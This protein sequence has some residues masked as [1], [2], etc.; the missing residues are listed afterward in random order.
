MIWRKLEIV[1]AFIALAFL[2][3][4][5]AKEPIFSCFS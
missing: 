5:I 3:F 2:L 4:T 1:V